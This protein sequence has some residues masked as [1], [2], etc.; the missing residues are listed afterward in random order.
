MTAKN[1]DRG[2]YFPCF[3][4]NSLTRK[5]SFGLFFGCLA[6][7]IDD[8]RIY[9]LKLFC[10]FKDATVAFMQHAILRTPAQKF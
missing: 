5:P 10:N 3:L 4:L 8:F 9:C 2:Y 1:P 7:H 6:F